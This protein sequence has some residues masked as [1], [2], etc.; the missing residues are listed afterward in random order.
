M[1]LHNLT[2]CPSRPWCKPCVHGQAA[3]YPH[4]TVVGEIVGSTVPRV[5][6][7]YC[8]LKENVRRVANEH[9]ENEEAAVSLMS[10]VM[11]ETMCN[12]VLDIRAEK[13]ECR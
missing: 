1:K 10:L 8:F 4:R 5:M 13:H 3:D 9:I 2:H 12:S 6:M 7:D 11:K